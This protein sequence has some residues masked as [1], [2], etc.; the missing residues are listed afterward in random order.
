MGGVSSKS[1]LE[2]R[3]TVARR[4]QRRTIHN[5]KP[6]I[7]NVYKDIKKFKGAARDANYIALHNEIEY[8]K[9]E[10]TRRG[11]D[12]QPQV[13]N[14]YENVYK[15]ICE[16]Q[17]ALEQKLQENTEKIEKKQKGKEE[18]AHLETVPEE[19]S[20]EIQQD[21]PDAA[22]AEE[23]RLENSQEKR[24]TVEL[25]FV[26]VVP[27]EDVPNA[28]KPANVRSP[29]EKRKSILKVGVPVMPGAMLKELTAHTNRITKFYDDTVAAE[30][31]PQQ[32]M[33][34]INEIVEDL[35]QIELEISQFVGKKHG[36]QYNK[37]R[38]ALN[39]YLVEVN[40]LESTDEYASEQQKICRNY[41]S[42][43]MSF[44]EERATDSGFI[45]GD[46]D[47]FS[48]NNNLTANVKDLSAVEA[49]FKLQSLL[50]NTQV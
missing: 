31:T 36:K 19:N 20:S 49:N 27:D 37:I 5:M 30:L 21:Q 18:N 2:R 1:P 39:K 41:V 43:C 38:N 12:L 28:P 44:L 33:I 10:L 22:E 24:K 7:D 13:R 25:K 9:N 47:V 46:D 42:S 23:E 14:L 35:Q 29:E 8:L 15:R 45:E 6:K 16:A 3:N 26:K 4:S 11:Q 34:K 17:E 32:I 48:S 40:R 50:K